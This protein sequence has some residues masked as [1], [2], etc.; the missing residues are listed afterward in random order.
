[1]IKSWLAAATLHIAILLEALEVDTVSSPLYVKLD[2]TDELRNTRANSGLLQR[3]TTIILPPIGQSARKRAT[4]T[5][6]P[7]TQ[8]RR[9][10]CAEL[11]DAF[12]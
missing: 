11:R 5:Q 2:R 7:P 3:G 12:D 6:V 4:L 9:F 1:V 10:L 8:A